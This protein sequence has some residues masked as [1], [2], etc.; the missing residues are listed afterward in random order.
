MRTHSVFLNFCSGFLCL[1]GACSPEDTPLSTPFLGV[2][3]IP[4]NSHARMVGKNFRR[5]VRYQQ[6]STE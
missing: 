6:Q 5:F 3:F 4:A 2:N 1:V